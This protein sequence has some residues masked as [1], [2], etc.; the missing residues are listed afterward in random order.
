MSQR[1]ISVIIPVYNESEGLDALFAVLAPFANY[2]EIIFVDGGS[3][4]GTERLIKEKGGN[5]ILSRKGRANQ[6]N[7]GA[8]V[9]SGE[10]LWFLHA[11][12]A[13]PPDALNQIRDTLKGGRRV[14]CFRIRFSSSH[15][16]MWIHSFLSNNYRTRILK[17]AFGDQGIFMEKALFEEMGGFAP[18]PLMEDYKFSRDL[19]RAGHPVKLAKG[20]II[21]SDRRYLANG[22]LRTMWRMQMLQRAFRKGHCIE[23]IAKTYD[24]MKKRKKGG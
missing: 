18:I 22:R 9:A 1:P 21:T 12:S 10:I 5:V 6:M 8:A 16:Y 17:I 4:D 3:N 13:A 15:P 14:G 19:R 24:S 7:S 2:C 20:H 23:E 11:D